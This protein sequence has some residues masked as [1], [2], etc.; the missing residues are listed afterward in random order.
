VTASP[1]DYSE[2]RRAARACIADR[3][4]MYTYD[5]RWNPALYAR[6]YQGMRPW[7]WVDHGREEASLRFRTHLSTKSR[8]KPGTNQICIQKGES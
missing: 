4:W 1:S 5:R 3:D 2:R 6:D 7:I 8:T